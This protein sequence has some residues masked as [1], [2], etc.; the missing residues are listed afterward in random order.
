MFFAIL[1]GIVRGQ[2]MLVRK[3][4]SPFG[5]LRKSSVGP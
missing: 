4:H 2:E 5:L 1:Y 3:I